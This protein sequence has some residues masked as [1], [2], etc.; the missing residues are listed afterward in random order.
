[1]NDKGMKLLKSFEGRRLKAY[2][3]VAGVWTIGYGHTNAAGEPKVTRGVI[4]TEDKCEAILRRDLRQY[5]LAVA[6]HV[7]VLLNANQRAALVSF[8]YNVGIGGFAR[9]SVLRVLNRSDYDAVPAK[10]ALWNKAGG[11]VLKGLVRRRGAEGD[12]FMTPIGNARFGETIMPKAEMALGKP[13]HKSTTIWSTLL[14]FASTAFASLAGMDW[15]IA[16]PLILVCAG[17]GLWIIRE[18]MCKSREDGV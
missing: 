6:T 9:S 11:R 5:E 3:D 18:R 12:L 14:S 10:L 4:I 1:M 15:K 2:K 7:K 16:V 17:F 13:A 8:C